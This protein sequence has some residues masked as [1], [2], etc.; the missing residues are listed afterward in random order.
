[1]GPNAFNS[2]LFLVTM[3]ATINTFV[4]NYRGRPFVQSLKENKMLWRSVQ[5]AF[6][7]LFICATEIFRP[8]NIL[9]QLSPMPTWGDVELDIGVGTEVGGVLMWFGKIVG[10]KGVLCAILVLQSALAWYVEE[11]IVK[12]FEGKKSLLLMFLR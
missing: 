6:A 10:F 4:V 7:A 2:A 5:V 9:L 3:C 8:L 12:H 11:K 1:M